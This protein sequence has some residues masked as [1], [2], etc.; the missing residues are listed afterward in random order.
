VRGPDTLRNALGIVL[1]LVTAVLGGLAIGYITADPPAGVQSAD[2]APPSQA[3]SAQSEPVAEPAAAAPEET[4][5]AAKT[6]APQQRPAP[7]LSPAS[8]QLAASEQALAGPELMLL[9][10]LDVAVLAQ[11]EQA[12]L[13]S[14]D[15]QALPPPLM[16]PDDLRQRLAAAGVDLGDAVDHLLAGLYARDDGDA[17]EEIGVAAILIGRIPIAEVEKA[18]DEAYQVERRPGPAGELLFVERRDKRTCEVQGPFAVAL[19]EARIVAGTPWAVEATL[20]RLADAQPAARDLAAWRVLRDGRILSFATVAPAE[21]VAR[22]L[23]RDPMSGAM[24]SASEEDLPHLQ[25]LAGG[26][27]LQAL[28]FTAEL[29]LDL[30]SDDAAWAQDL[31]H[32]FQQGRERLHRD[33]GPDLPSLARLSEHLALQAD[34]ETLT[35]NLGLDR[36]AVEDAG[37]LPGELLRVMFMGFAGGQAVSIPADS[38]EADEQLADPARAIRYLPSVSH[39]G[40]PSYESLEDQTFP[41]EAAS[42]P[43]G[44]RVAAARLQ[45]DSQDV[46]EIAVEAASARIPN[47]P[48][49]DF[50]RLEERTTASLNITAVRDAAGNDLLRAEDCGED[51]NDQ[52]TPLGIGEHST[53]SG[54]TWRTERRAAGTKKVR[55]N[56]GARLGDVAEIEG[57]ITLNL[58]E[59]TETQRL[60]APFAGQTIES[61]GVR[62]ELKEAGEQR[63]S[64]SV[65]GETD[66]L[67]SVRAFNAQGQALATAGTA[68]GGSV[69]GFERKVERDFQ[70]QIASAE[71]VIATGL[72]EKGYPFRLGAGYPAFER[73]D[74]PAPHQVAT[75]SA[76]DFAAGTAVP[77]KTC[78][79][80]E[81]AG[82]APPFRL[83]LERISR[84]FGP[85]YQVGITVM[86]P[87]SPALEGNL[88]GAELRID[89]LTL[90]D[91]R[92]I[93]VSQGEFI[94]LRWESYDEVMRAQSY[95]TLELQEVVEPDTIAEVEGRLIVRLPSRL[96]RLVLPVGEPGSETDDANGRSLALLGFETGNVLL[97]L[98]GERD[99][100]VQFHAV[101]DG[102]ADAA[103]IVH[104]LDDGQAAGPWQ[105]TVATSGR[106]SRIEAVFAAE[107][108]VLEF[109]FRLPRN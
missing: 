15:P 79:N 75:A 96:D 27:T 86:G 71:F 30:A 38:Q 61:A 21:E 89:R 1:L 82:E 9:F 13:G 39:S 11:I 54:D 33:Y 85:N 45:E 93:E 70:G 58:A 74:Y 99:R 87:Q 35:F 50:H 60:D 76:D 49:D 5:Q 101:D 100:L 88:S 14:D 90:A 69:G 8:D 72:A 36:Q 106:P 51:R 18:L 53:Y 12:M 4:A 20:Q 94:S 40:L 84:F 103:T 62:I 41:P 42:G 43:F 83:C 23:A 92:Q 78:E 6:P 68:G 29:T 7:P 24:V 47:P 22:R 48:I 91:G 52:P 95:L 37:R 10:H 107:R 26:L 16:D 31:A 55:L 34:G 64:Y 105:A 17:G 44:L 102:G 25:R 28:P 108:E 97:R 66:R 59:T 57:E 32:Q 109:P 67:L 104:Y 80:A 98:E 3:P 2:Q 77:A 56:P 19:D 73:W 46:I 81:A 63:L 65:S